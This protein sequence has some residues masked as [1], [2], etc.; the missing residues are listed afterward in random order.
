V[1]KARRDPDTTNARDTMSTPIVTIEFNRPLSD[2]LKIMH[3][4][5]IRRLVVTRGVLANV[6]G[7]VTERRILD[8]LV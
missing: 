1:V 8:F 6:V 3:E 2:A 5:R 4:K 7:I